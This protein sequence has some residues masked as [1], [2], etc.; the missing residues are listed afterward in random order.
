MYALLA[1]QAVP[2]ANTAVAEEEPP[3]HAALEQ[4]SR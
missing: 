4:V 1:R 2:G 3:A